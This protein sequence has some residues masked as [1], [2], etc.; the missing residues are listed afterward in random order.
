M[1]AKATI[2]RLMLNAKNL[3]NWLS[4]QTSRPYWRSRTERLEACILESHI[5]GAQ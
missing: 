5:L 2:I 3:A 1:T 4:G